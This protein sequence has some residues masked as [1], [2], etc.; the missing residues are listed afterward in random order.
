[1]YTSY[2]WHCLFSK[3]YQLSEHCPRA[4]LGK[5]LLRH[6]IQ[7]FEVKGDLPFCAKQSREA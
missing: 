5:T 2:I 1:M 6:V 3:N 4:L 7:I